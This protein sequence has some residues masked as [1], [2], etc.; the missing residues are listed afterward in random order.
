M[1]QSLKKDDSKKVQESGKKAKSIDPK[2]IESMVET[3]VGSS[4]EASVTGKT[5][6]T[7]MKS[8]KKNHGQL[9]E[10]DSDVDEDWVT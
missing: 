10:S 7:K 9:H 1:I 3:F 8:L 2:N 4:T 5:F 6:L